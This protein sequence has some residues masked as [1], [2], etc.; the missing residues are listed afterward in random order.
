MKF[1]NA[2]RRGDW[3]TPDTSAMLQHFHHAL[4]AIGSMV[5][6]DSGIS[7]MKLQYGLVGGLEHDFYFS[8][9]YGIILPI[10]VYIFQDGRYT[11]N[12]W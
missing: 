5:W 8:I 6:G 10:D 11:T 9:I 7:F 2:E 3:D 4:I 1:R 12:Q